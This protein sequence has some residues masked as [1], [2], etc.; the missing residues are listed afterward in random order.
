MTA[1][2]NPGKQDKLT[3]SK[4]F[5]MFAREYRDHWLCSE[6]EQIGAF[7]LLLLDARHSQTKEPERWCGKGYH[8]PR[9]SLL[10]SR[11][12]LAKKFG[13]GW[14]KERVRWFLDTLKKEGEVNWEPIYM[15]MILTLLNYEAWQG[16]VERDNDR[17]NRKAAGK[18][19]EHYKDFQLRD[20]AQEQTNSRHHTSNT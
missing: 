14:T 12:D 2:K 19:I 20:D 17:D 4:G 18:S 10:T 3:N 5:L 16:M 15:G 6:A 8:V 13:D 1:K 11:T 9:G 7:L